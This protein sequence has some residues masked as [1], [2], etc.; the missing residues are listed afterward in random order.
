MKKSALK[1][2]VVTPDKH[3]PY[4]DMPAINVVCKAIELVKPDIY[5]DLGDT[6]EWENFS[7]WKWKRKR[8]P[9]LEMLIPQLETDVIDVNDG[10]DIIDESLDKVGCE[11]K[12]F[13]EGNHELWLQMFV[14]EHPYVPQ[15]ATENALKLKE[16]GYKFHPCGKLLKIGKMNFYHGHH[17]GGQ[18]HAAN[19]L[20]KLGGN[21]MYGHWH[22]VQY[23]SATHMDGAKGAWSIGCLKDMSADKNAWLGNRKI[24]WGHAFAIVDFYDKGRFTVDVVQIIDGKATVWG[25]LIDGNK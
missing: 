14:E 17:Y 16:R 25:E 8:K 20:R 9:P 18:Y 11:E 7:H 6:G 3:F 5:I 24:N 12:H 2:A 23:M 15:Y 19:H 10:M 21:V 1:R 13:C 22:D 4:A